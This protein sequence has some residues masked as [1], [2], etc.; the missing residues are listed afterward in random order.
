MPLELEAELRAEVKEGLLMPELRLFGT[1]VEL[2]GLRPVDMSEHGSILNPMHLVH[3]LPGLREGQRWKVPL[4][5]PL[6]M[7]SAQHLLG[8]PLGAAA[9]PCLEAEVDS[10][11]LTWNLQEV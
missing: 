4:L 7:F 3:R 8:Q 10:G 9:F 2:P 1:P 5:D 6:K 11:T